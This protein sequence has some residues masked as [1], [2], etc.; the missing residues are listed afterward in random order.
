MSRLNDR[1]RRHDVYYR[2]AKQESFAARSVYKLQEIDKRVRLLR[3]GQRVLDLGCRPGSW[4]QYAAERVGPSGAVVGLDR[5]ALDIAV[6]SNAR[7]IEGDVLTL[8]PA[9]LTE[10]LPED[11]R[12]CFQVILSDMAPD[13]SGIPFTDQVRSVE[14]FTAALELALKLGCPSS[15]LCGKIFMGDGF[16]ETVKRLKEHYEQV[17]TIRPEATRKSST[18]VYLVCLRRRSSP[19]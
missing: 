18:E 15:S 5:Q 9:T 19:L 3:A 11:R 4:L 16:A 8:D 14:L 17:K 1:R 7:V 6:P 12:G 13:T 2:R 10:A